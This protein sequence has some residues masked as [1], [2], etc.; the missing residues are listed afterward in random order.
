MSGDVEDGEGPSDE[1]EKAVEGENQSE[2]EPQPEPEPL[3]HEEELNMEEHAAEIAQTRI[4]ELEMN[5]SN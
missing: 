3:P 2:P 4:G 1:V 5:V